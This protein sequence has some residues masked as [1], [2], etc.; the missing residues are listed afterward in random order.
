[1]MKS[2]IETQRTEVDG[3][4]TFWAATYGPFTGVV[5]F[6]VGT[7]DETLPTRG[8]THLVEHL[9]LWPLG[10]RQRYEFDASVDGLFT[11]FWA[12]GTEDEAVSFFHET[13]STLS[14]LPLERVELEK[15]VLRTE[16]EGWSGAVVPMMLD[17]RFG[18]EGHGLRNY[19]EF[20]LSRIDEAEIAS[21]AKERLTRENAALWLSAHRHR[22]SSSIC[23]QGSEC[24]RSSP[25][26]YRASCT[27]P[28]IA[29]GQAASQSVCSGATGLISP[30]GSSS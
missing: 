10:G 5:V 20:G 2:L 17:C 16:A 22:G 24:R 30:R 28:G 8:I 25:N 18:A 7:S 26:R 27:R 12:R 13:L 23:P 14:D 15:R 4:P 19:D 6:R 9:A 21:W 1:M 3:V 29:G 11:T